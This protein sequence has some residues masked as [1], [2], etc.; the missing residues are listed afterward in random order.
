LQVDV[1]T[2]T[3]SSNVLVTGATGLI[4]GEIVRCLGRRGLGRVCAL[5]RPSADCD[6]HGRFLER[7]RRSGETE[8]EVLSWGVDVVPGDIRQ[9]FWD[10]P[11]DDLRR[12]TEN[13]DVILHCAADTSFLC[14]KNVSQTNVAGTS[15]LIELAQHCRKRP[16]IAY[17]STATNGGK[18]ASHLCLSE[19][20][21]C[22]PENEHYN[23]YT[24]S[25][26]VAETMLRQSGLPVLTLRP[27]IVFSAGLP[28]ADFA[29]HILWFVPLA[30]VFNCIPLDP[31]SRLDLVPVSYVTDA[32]I[33]LLRKP[34]RKYDCY[35]LSAGEHC[36][37]RIGEL[38]D[39]VNRFYRRKR[40]LQLVTPDAWTKELYR[41]HVSSPRQR[42]VFFGLRYYLPFLNMDVVYD[43]GR[44]QE[45]LGDQSPR[46]TPMKEYMGDL[47]KLI[48]S[49]RAL[50]EVAKP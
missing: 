32:T 1:P 49:R 21:G 25:K 24:R 6:A 48:K 35:H 3:A 47:L 18:Y 29:Q 28:D 42:K 34:D 26:A 45:E 31:A 12:V 44:L 13:V 39:F 50:Q 33:D 27:T 20:D 9:P 4:G 5:V 10:L 46:I 17:M 14:Q 2:L 19:D 38:N 8:Q 30:R 37:A 23:E 41:T 36:C 16:L 11:P 15:Y 40:P 22:K 43:N 7:M